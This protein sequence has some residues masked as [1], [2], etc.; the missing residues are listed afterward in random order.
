M[1]KRILYIVFLALTLMG[2]SRESDLR[3]SIFI[4]DPENPDL[5]AYTEWGYNTFG[6]YINN[7]LFLYADNEEPLMITATNSYV[8]FMFTG[9]RGEAW[10]E[11]T[12]TKLYIQTSK[13]LPTTA[14]DLASLNGKA[15]N[16]ADPASAVYISYNGT[17]TKLTKLNGTI[18]FDRVQRIIIDKKYTQ[19][20]L[21]G[22]FDL[23]GEI[24][25]GGTSVRI[26]DGRFD[27]GIREFTNFVYEP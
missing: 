17:K 16:L 22:H 8:E 20:I 23:S 19:M 18:V 4:P 11:G 13:I 10:H 1:M 6:A 26:T 2:C 7:D 12:K 5:P 3:K 21:S 25:V 15:V 14:E 27:S 24:G 9:Y